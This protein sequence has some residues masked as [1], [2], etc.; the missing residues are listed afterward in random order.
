MTNEI[1]VWVHLLVDAGRV[2]ERGCVEQS[3]G[4]RDLS[5]SEPDGVGGAHASLVA[6]DASGN[7]WR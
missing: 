7:A 4:L 6:T 1:A 2:G 5:S 3:G